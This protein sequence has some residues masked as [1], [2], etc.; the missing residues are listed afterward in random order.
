M[1]NKIWLFAVSPQL[2]TLPVYP[3]ILVFDLQFAW[4]PEPSKATS[5]LHNLVIC[6]KLKKEN[7][8]CMMDFSAGIFENF[9]LLK[10][11]SIEQANLGNYKPV[12]PPPQES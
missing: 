6:G 8:I 5:L 1:N 4:Q 2:F 12:N 3:S 9:W 10:N 7:K 11:G